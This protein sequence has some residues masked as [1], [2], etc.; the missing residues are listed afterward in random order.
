MKFL[1]SSGHEI[2]YEVAKIQGGENSY[3]FL[4]C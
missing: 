4:F 3:C 1:G 2:P